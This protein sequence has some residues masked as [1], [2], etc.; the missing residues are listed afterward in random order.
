MLG[1]L[2]RVF[3]VASNEEAQQEIQNNI[4]EIEARSDLPLHC[5][6]YSLSGDPESEKYIIKVLLKYNINEYNYGDISYRVVNNKLSTKNF[7]L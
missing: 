7:D 6:L 2:D 1:F 5:E 4:E 3:G